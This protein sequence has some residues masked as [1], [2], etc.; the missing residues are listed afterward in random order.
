[1]KFICDKC[2]ICYDSN[3]GYDNILIAMKITVGYEWQ[4]YCYNCGKRIHDALNAIL[5]ESGAEDD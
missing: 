5:D 3:D 1:M 4:H 2:K